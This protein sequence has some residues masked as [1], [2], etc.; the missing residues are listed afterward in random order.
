MLILTADWH[1]RKTA[2]SFRKDDF[3]LALKRKVKQIFRIAVTHKAKILIAGDL[4]DKSQW[5]NSLL[6]WFI[7]IAKRVRRSGVRILVIPGQHDLYGHDLS[8]WRKNALGV[9]QHA[10]AIEVLV[11]DIYIIDDIAI[12]A[13]P[14]GSSDII[15]ERKIPN[16]KCKILMLHRLTFPTRV[17]N[18]DTSVLIGEE[19]LEYLN[20]AD[21]ILTGDNHQTFTCKRENRILVN[22]GSLLRLKINQSNH[23][24]CIFLYDEDE[25]RLVRKI[26]L[27][28]DDDIVKKEYLAKFEKR[29]ELEKFINRL[30]IHSD[31]S[32]NFEEN[33]QKLLSV[34]VN[35]EVKEKVLSIL[36]KAR[37]E[38]R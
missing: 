20:W 33:L 34:E 18:W 5:S 21:L 32:V 22:P 16:A 13:K 26:Y 11:D 30:V 27:E 8:R 38:I 19:L 3:S 31:H 29:N 1:L 4:G 23:K 6:S 37:R 15:E 28:C 25:K 14:Y 2:P 24:P 9:L 35:N 12:V 36:E 17:P 10:G 7:R